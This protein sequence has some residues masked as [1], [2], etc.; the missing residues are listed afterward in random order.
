MS[1]DA[2]EPSVGT[3]SG[4]RPGEGA[5]GTALPSSA[6]AGGVA[7]SGSATP[8]VR[9][10]ARGSLG[11]TALGSG[12]GGNAFLV[13]TATAGLLIDAGFSR[14]AI[15]ARL[16]RAGLDPGII[17]ALLIT[18]EHGDHVAGA[19]VLADQ[20][21]VPTYVSRETGTVLQRAGKLGREVVCFAPGASFA[22]A[23]FMVQAFAVPHDAVE[24]V[25]F[26]IERDGVALALASDLGHLSPLARERLR[27]CQLLALE[28]NH[29]E[30]MQLR[31][32]RH[33]RH[34][35]RVLGRHGHL[36]N[37]EAM[38]CLDQVLGPQ[39]QRLILVHLSRECNSLDLVWAMARQRL[40]ELG[41][42]DIVLDVVT[43]DEPLPT[44]WVG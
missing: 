4:E 13:H 22:V 21:G 43:Q 11:F 28:S 42:N 23:G 31:S 34:K 29:D 40:A 18:H 39:T 26:R 25:G 1:V 30:E 5:G 10:S 16:S 9:S 27:N 12:S 33:L 19:R 37:R 38:A 20:L 2:S 32:D 6:T 14:S 41:R 36:S 15:L 17:R 7:P 24:P 35:R 44:A 3:I 8:L